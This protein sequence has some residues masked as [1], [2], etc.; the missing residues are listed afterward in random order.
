MRLYE[1]PVYNNRKLLIVPIGDIQFTGT[2][3]DTAGGCSINHLNSFLTQIKELAK[4][5]KA[6]IAWLGTGDY[7]DLIS[8]SNRQSYKANGLYP[9]AKRVITKAVINVV[10]ELYE[11][12][13]PHIRGRDIVTLC[14]GHHWFS[15]HASLELPY[16]DTDQHLASLFGLTKRAD[17]GVCHGA[18]HVTFTWGDAEYRVL[19]QHGQGNGQSLAYGLNKLD[20]MAGGWER[21]DAH[22]MGHTHKS[23]SVKKA[24][25]SIEGNEVVHRDVRLITSGAFL[26]GWKVGEVLY[27][28]GGQMSP[29]P[30]G[31]SAILVW[32]NT[33]EPSGIS[34]VS[35]T[36]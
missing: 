29:L 3:P 36:L 19:F 32:P 8:P 1:H 27:P 2:D 5:H 31:G 7:V 24:K 23:G 22:V 12:L 30:L 26:K 10:D 21:V 14:L 17:R 18:G 6:Q 25:L 11:I 35:M 20:K 28:E 33:K 15:Y 9:T 34:S 13:K 4:A 16:S